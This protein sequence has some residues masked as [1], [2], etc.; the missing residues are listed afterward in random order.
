M[1]EPL[2]VNSSLASS[3]GRVTETD[4]LASTLDAAAHIDNAG[5]LA[6][7][8]CRA[9]RELCELLRVVVEYLDFHRLR[10]GGELGLRPEDDVLIFVTE[11]ITDPTNFARII[12]PEEY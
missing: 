7:G 3:A 10:H 6:D 4:E 12:G 2:W 9:V 1:P 11:G 5:T 8:R